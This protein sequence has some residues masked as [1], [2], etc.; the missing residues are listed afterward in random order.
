MISIGPIKTLSYSKLF[1]ILFSLLLTVSGLYSQVKI[2]ERPPLLDKQNTGLSYESI[3]RQKLDLNGEWDLSFNEGETFTKVSVP[4]AYEFS[5]S[6]LFKKQFNVT[7]S[8]LSN[9]SFILIAEGIINESSIRINGVFIVNN[10]NAFIPIVLPI[11]E[12]IIREQNTIEI[13]VNSELS[14]VNTIPLANQL[15]YSRLYG[16]ITK[17]IYIIAVPKVCVLSSD[18]SYNLSGYNNV[19]FDN[20]V[21]IRSSSLDGFNRNQFGIKTQVIDK[22]TGETVFES[23]VTP[24]TVEN[25]QST[26]VDHSFNFPNPKLW[27]FEK[28]NL[29]VFKTQIIDSSGVI[30]ELQS[31]IGIR[32]VQVKGQTVF[33]N[34]KE[35]NLKGINYY[36]DSPDYASALDYYGVEG[37]LKNIKDLGINC[38]RVPGRTPHPYIVNLC[39][40]LGLLLFCEIPFNEV[41][42]AL[43]DNNEYVEGSLNYLEGAIRTYKNNPSIIAWGIGNNFDVTKTVSA[44]YVRLAKERANSLDGRPVYY[45]TRNFNEDMCEEFADFRGL[46]LIGN[47]M[48]NLKEFITALTGNLFKLKNKP[49]KPVFISSYGLSIENENRNGARDLHSIEAQ[50]QYIIEVYKVVSKQFFVNF[51]SSYADLNSER[52]LNYRHNYNP[53]LQTNGIFTIYREPKQA[54]LFVKRVINNQDT[55]KILEGNPAEEDSQ[56]FLI[57]GIVLNIGLIFLIF[58]VRKFQEYS[59][60]SLL[61]PTNFFQFASEQMLIPTTLNFFLCLLISFGLGLFFSSVFYFYRESILFDMVLANIWWADSLKILFSEVTNS[62]LYSIFFLTGVFFLVQLLISLFVFILSFFLS[63]RAYYKN[64][65]T[66]T[67]WS[68]LQMVIFLPIGTVIFKLAQVDTEYVYLSVILFIILLIIYIIRIIKGARTIY[69]LHSF[70]AYSYGLAITIAIFGGF[71]AYFYF[72]KHT[73]YII[74]LINSYLKG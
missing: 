5:G 12:D 23:P 39:N 34:G 3:T 52:P 18:L 63:G 65:F 67:I 72:V 62:P 17:D 36:E 33:I 50:A 2:F 61:R 58:N 8:I 21:N 41:P 37:D 20:K 16:G 71:Y 4:I 26:I 9:Y 35:Y 70:K 74:S 28:P 40:K 24:F 68:A 60:K 64:V 66:V 59:V 1:P 10:K 43:L 49:A 25:F 32:R 55:P 22:S 14:T 53:F 51:I 31:E 42:S 11:D 48:D 73:Q 6:A 15:N 19:T 45:T 47:K 56:I 27:S 13:S 29:Y 30:D 54:A 44:D 7:Q 57:A 38:I 46:D 69:N